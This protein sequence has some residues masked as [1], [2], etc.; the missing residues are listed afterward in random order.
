MRPEV[1][2]QHCEETRVPLRKAV[3]GQLH[4]ALQQRYAEAVICSHFS[5]DHGLQLRHDNRAHF[6]HLTSTFPYFT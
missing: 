4:Q 5:L 3:R 1:P 2:H 6:H